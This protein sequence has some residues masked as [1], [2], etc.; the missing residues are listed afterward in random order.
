MVRF[1]DLIL[2][3]LILVT[4]AFLIVFTAMTGVATSDLLLNPLVLCC[5]VYVGYVWVRAMLDMKRAWKEDKASLLTS[6]QQI[7][8]GKFEYV[9]VFLIVFFG[10]IYCFLTPPMQVSD[11]A[12]H[13]YRAYE[14]SGLNFSAAG[15]VPKNVAVTGVSLVGTLP[16]RVRERAS[17]PRITAAFLLPPAEDDKYQLTNGLHTARHYPPVPYIGSAIGIALGRIF[18]F[19]PVVLMYMGRICNMLL[20][21]ALVFLTYKVLPFGKVLLA[22]L[23][24]L[25]MTLSL[26]SSLSADGFTAI[27][28][29]LCVA[30]FLSFARKQEKLSFGRLIISAAMLCVAILAKNGAY[31]GFAL[32]I[33]LLPSSL[34]S[35]RR[36]QFCFFGI[37]AAASFG[38]VLLWQQFMRFFS[39]YGQMASESG[40]QRIL[41]H[42]WE[43]PIWIYQIFTQMKMYMLDTF[44]GRLGWNDTILPLWIR[45]SAAVIL[46]SFALFLNFERLYPGTRQ[47]I[48]LLGAATGNFLL[49]VYA[50]FSLRILGIQGRYFIPLALC[51]LL[52]F[53]S[54]RLNLIERVRADL[55]PGIQL[56]V[57]IG[58]VVYFSAVHIT[59]F[60][61]LIARYWSI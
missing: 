60:G 16:N 48:V 23:V 17:F 21:A 44:V 1:L 26:A 58:L 45:I 29:Y 38:L 47:R 12:A 8:T 25:P 31:I 36:A 32:L 18:G 34:F 19:P 10:S 22:C 61:V 40:T 33:F 35:S 49:I 20:F 3:T 30:G 53:T 14:V 24:L 52:A 5:L 28:C 39:V 7:L 55:N 59:A 9:L 57:M 37:T 46:V 4:V 13:F 41:E 50:L 2:T 42:P 54:R 15:V 43:Y 51:F 11:E 56:A 6:F 27:F